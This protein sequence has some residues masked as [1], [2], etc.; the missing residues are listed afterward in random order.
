[1]TSSS[2]S[3]H[4]SSEPVASVAAHF[5][6]WVFIATELLFFSPLLLGYY[7]GRVAFP[8]GFAQASRHTDVIIGTLNTAILLTSSLVMALAVEL[9]RSV[10]VRTYRTLLILT[11]L[12]GLAFL[13]LKGFEYATEWREGLFPNRHFHFATPHEHAAQLFFFLYF[14]M[15]AIHGLHLLIGI[16]LV[17]FLVVR[18]KS[19]SRDTA[20]NI[21]LYWHF[22]DIVW[23]FLY[24]LLY[25]VS[26]HG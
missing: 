23:I 11:A 1:M 18:G 9:R 12:L 14:A 21:G 17:S 4:F 15:T 20:I 19:V 5:G 8:E 13:A 16:G 26:R 22:V 2:V 6:M 7:Y 3:K 10:S 24:P 25:L